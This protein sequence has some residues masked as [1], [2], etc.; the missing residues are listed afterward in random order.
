M[1]AYQERLYA[2][3]S[4]WFGALAFACACGWVI[5]VATTIAAGFVTLVVVGT[6]VVAGVH[7]YG[8][9]SVA[10]DSRTFTAGAAQLPLRFIGEVTELD[11]AAWRH[12]M[13]PGADARAFVMTRPYV[14]GGVM[15]TLTD[16]NDPAPYWL[17]S[18]RH[19]H[20]LTLALTHAISHDGTHT[21]GA[22]ENGDR[23]DSG[24]ENDEEG[25]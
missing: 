16:P 10:V 1:E 15:A 19:P 18:S 25:R 24:G 22:D 23:K 12:Q 21:S 13:G 5:L 9:V 17:V 6:I 2:P 3:T 14:S 4:W 7:V 11:A 20:D 8:R